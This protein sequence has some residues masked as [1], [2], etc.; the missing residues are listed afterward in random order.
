MFFLILIANYFLERLEY[1]F[2]W[3]LLPFGI[4]FSYR[5][6][7]FSLDHQIMIPRTLSPNPLQHVTRALQSTFQKIQSQT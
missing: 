6:G 7:A 2:L 3:N 4:F 1:V 5:A